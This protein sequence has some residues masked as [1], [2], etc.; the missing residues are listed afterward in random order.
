MRLFGVVIVLFVLSSAAVFAMW[1]KS[2]LSRDD[3]AVMKRKLVAIA[4]AI[5]DPKGYTKEDEKF[6]LPTSIATNNGSYRPA[7]AS[8]TL[9]FANKAEKKAQQ[10]RAQ[11]EKDRERQVQEA[12]MRGDTAALKRL[13]EEQSSS[14]SEDESGAQEH[15]V[16]V[17]IYLNARADDTIDPDNVVFEKPGILAL[18]S[19]S[20]GDGSYTENVAIYCDPVGLKNTKQLSKATVQFPDTGVKRKN[21]IVNVW[22]LIKG[23]AET[24]KAYAKGIDA[25]AV[26]S[27][28]E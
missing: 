2:D 22:I 6:S 17:E 7:E 3:V 8:L 27:Q 13:L 11:G 21:A 12:A 23:P 18:Y 16:S 5:G 19:R 15:P 14:D 24:I 9:T 28:I 26:L 20:G 25:A 4:K 10:D 1:E